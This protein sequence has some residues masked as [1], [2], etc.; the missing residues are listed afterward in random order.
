MNRSLLALALVP[1]VGC[2]SP[3]EQQDGTAVGN[4]GVVALALGTPADLE[5]DATEAVVGLATVTPCGEGEPVEIDLGDELL[6]LDEG[7]EADLPG[8]TWCSVV[9]EEV[10]LTIDGRLEADPDDGEYSLLLEVGTVTLNAPS[11]SGFTVDEDEEFVL[12]LAGLD[13]LS[14]ADLSLTGGATVDVEPE[15]ALHDGLATTVADGTAL[16]D[17]A[18][19]DGEVSTAERDTG[20]EA[21]VSNPTPEPDTV[22]GAGPACSASDGRAT[23]LALLLA[24]AAGVGRRRS[25]PRGRNQSSQVPATE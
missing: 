18:D 23:W 11:F 20:T 24:A 14:A 21:S 8:G 2:V 25:A 10:E 15:D 19:G 9:L 22:P 17:D 1:V 4:P 13:W 5:V 6:D 7:V 3:S 12:E 16:Y